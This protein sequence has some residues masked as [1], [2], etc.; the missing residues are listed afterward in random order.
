MRLTRQS[1][2]PLF[3]SCLA[4]C[5]ISACGGGAG[6]ASRLAPNVVAAD[7]P[8]AGDAVS[9][10]PRT[11]PAAIEARVELGRRLFYDGRLAADGMRS[12]ASCHKQN[13]AFADDLAF[14][15]GVTGALTARNAMMLANVGNARTLTWAN[16]GLGSLE[17]QARLPLFGQKPVEMGMLGLEPLMVS[18]LAQEPVYAGLFRDAYP[19]Q[20]DAISVDNI[21]LALAAFE[22]TLVSNSA[23]Y[24]LYRRGLADLSDQAKRGEML[25]RSD[26]LKC[27]ACHTGDDFSDAY[28]PGPPPAQRFHNIG[29]YNTDGRGGYPLSDAGLAGVT[30]RP[31]D[32]GRFRTPSLRNIA[33]TAPYMHDGSLPTLDSV[34]DHYASGGR[35]TPLGQANAGDGR[36]SPLKD[37]RVSGFALSDAERSDLL[38]FLSSLTDQTFLTDVR[39]ADPWR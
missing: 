15:W 10:Q 14:S 35:L 33:V 23:P 11:A 7:M 1:L 17:A 37:P 25:F 2:S 32:V 30:G 13:R 16:H 5:L 31:E 39:Y 27:S 18:R 21:L 8:Q 6:N 36:L 29:L 4:L 12:C 19:G 3:I 28:G 24:D 20:A 9:P 22:R 38:A 34:I 26:R